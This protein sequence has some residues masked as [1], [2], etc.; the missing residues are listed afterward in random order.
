[1]LL[2]KYCLGDEMT[3]DEV[4]R[5]CGTYGEDRNIYWVLVGKS[6]GKRPLERR[7]HKWEDNIEIDHTEIGWEGMDWICLS[8][9]T[10]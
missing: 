5:A 1:M 3:E 4:G 8:Q 6:E 10:D 9:D 7:R 2:T